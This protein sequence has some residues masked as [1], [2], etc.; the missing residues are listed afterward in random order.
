MNFD[1][2]SENLWV[3]RYE[4]EKDN[5]LYRLFSQWNDV[6]YLDKFFRENYDDLKFFKVDSIS[7]AISDTIEDSDILE[8][9]F[10][11]M[12]PEDDLKAVFN[13][14]THKNKESFFEKVKH[15]LGKVVYKRNA[16]HDSWLRIYALNL[17]EGVYMI[18]GGAIKLTGT[19]GERKH[20]A[21]EL[22]KVE[23]VRNFL[24]SNGIVDRNGF[25]E[26]IN[27]ISI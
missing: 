22:V 25:Q 4:N 24:I 11:D 21:D 8:S 13:S 6:M 16:K 20:T 1:C 19:M 23:N 26:Y 2:I 3:V 17:G 12:K 5:E 9:V 15:K 10:L 14:L 18:T 7:D 27:E